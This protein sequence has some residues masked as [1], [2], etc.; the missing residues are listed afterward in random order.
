M[1]SRLT[2]LSAM[3]ARKRNASGAWG[4]WSRTTIAP[5]RTKPWGGYGGRCADGGAHPMR[6]HQYIGAAGS[7]GGAV[8]PSSAFTDLFGRLACLQLLKRIVPP[9]SEEAD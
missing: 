2:A 1:P 3:S 4:C 5:S 9:L 8:A 7:G 6:M